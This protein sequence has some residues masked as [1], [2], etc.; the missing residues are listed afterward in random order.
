VSATVNGSTLTVSSN[1]VPNYT[2]SIG[3]LEIV[4]G[5]S[6]EIQEFGDANPNSIGE[7][8]WNFTIPL[9]PEYLDDPLTRP[10]GMGAIGV[11][12]NGVPLFNPFADP[13]HADAIEQEVFN[14]CCG[15]PAPSTSPN[16]GK[17]H[18]H[19]FPTCL[20]GGKGSGQIAIN[21]S[22]N[23]TSANV[24]VS[25]KEYHMA[26][27]LDAQLQENTHSA[28]L[29]FA[30]DGHPVYGPIGTAQSV[31]IYNSTLSVRLLRSSYTGADDSSGN[32]TYVANSGDLDEC[33]GLFSV[34]PEYPY[35]VYHYVATIQADDWSDPSDN[36]TYGKRVLRSVNYNYVY[37][38]QTMY[39]IPLGSTTTPDTIKYLIQ[40]EYNRLDSGLS[41]SERY[42]Q[43]YRNLL[44]N[45]RDRVGDLTT[46]TTTTTTN[47]NYGSPTTT[48]TPKY[49]LVRD[50]TQGE[51]DRD[52][53]MIVPAFPYL[54]HYYRGNIG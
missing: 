8:D 37:D 51:I 54:F 19:K 50:K 48:T 53:G 15:H 6:D 1:G 33:N 39:G 27:I 22:F 31:G 45:F 46:T 38:F 30:L 44:D 52:L 43:A 41:N 7:Q 14:S 42:R 11:A 17:Y 34:T 29:G 5:W 3:S 32:P 13:Q 21:D 2:P 25:N 36:T 47:Y 23:D 16:V 20:A 18:Y 28:L 10:T 9:N 35:G 24:E 49:P 40:A 4:E 26:D 12:L